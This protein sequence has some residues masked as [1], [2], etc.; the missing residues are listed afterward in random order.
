[1]EAAAVV[2][3]RKTTRSRKC[4]TWNAILIILEKQL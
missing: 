3:M 2:K 4:S 1:M